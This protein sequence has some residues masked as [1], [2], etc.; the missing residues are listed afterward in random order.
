M[1]EK[2]TYDDIIEHCSKYD[3]THRYVSILNKYFIV[4]KKLPD[5]RTDEDRPT[6]K[7]AK[8]AVYF[9]DKLEVVDIL[10]I[11]DKSNSP[12]KLQFEIF[13]N[14]CGEMLFLKLVVGKACEHEMYDPIVYKYAERNRNRAFDYADEW[15][16]GFDVGL[17]YFKSVKRAL[18]DLMLTNKYKT[19]YANGNKRE[20]GYLNEDNVKTGKWIAWNDDGTLIYEGEYN[21]CCK[22]KNGNWTHY[23]LG[24]K[25]CSGM[26][27]CDERFGNWISYENLSEYDDYTNIPY[28]F[29][30]F[31]LDSMVCPKY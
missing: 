16:Y 6:I 1:A 5:S 11:D 30:T 12:T 8:N 4:F 27:R 31:R 10:N 19:Y 15:A 9:A 20:F 26:Y 2:W 29:G 17:M 21:G 25:I 23:K 18:A 13:V 14:R 22:H 7:N 28:D 24:N 3:D